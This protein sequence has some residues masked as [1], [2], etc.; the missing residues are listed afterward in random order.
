M[1]S[2]T[3]TC[4]TSRSWSTDQSAEAGGPILVLRRWRELERDARQTLREPH[5]HT[6]AARLLE[7]FRLRC[8]RSAVTG[9]TD[10]YHADWCEGV[11]P[12][13]G[14]REMLL[15]SGHPAAIVTN[16][17]YP[18]LVPGQL[19]RFGL[20]DSFQFITTSVEHGF[21]TPHPTIYQRA[22]AAARLDPADVLFVGDDAECDYHGPKA[23]AIRA[24]VVSPVPVASVPEE[25]RIGHILELEPVS[26]SCSGLPSC[27]PPSP[28]SP[29]APAGSP[30]LAL[31]P[32]RPASGP[33]TESDH[34]TSGAPAP[35][36]P[37]GHRA[38][39][40][41]SRMPGLAHG[42]RRHPAHSLADHTPT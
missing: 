33:P 11:E 32:S 41:P 22:L 16:T 26:M 36:C 15:R 14:I 19:Q 29:P 6:A 25:D 8:E 39:D 40:R 13:P 2:G 23:A 5:W 10:A 28:A 17:Y 30:G 1:P 20:A 31:A 35:G 12:I 21:R 38:L 34:G 3:A 42:L 18:P 27:T 7:R 4:L 9:F 37:G 24:V